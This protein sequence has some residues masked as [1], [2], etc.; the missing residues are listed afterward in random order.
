MECK[1]NEIAK[2]CNCK[3]WYVPRTEEDD[4]NL[5]I[6]GRRGNICFTEQLE[7]YEDEGKCSHC[8]DDCTMVHFFTA[9]KREPYSRNRNEKKKL[10]DSDKSTGLLANYLLDKKRIF[11]DGFSRNLTKFTFNMTSDAQLAEERFN[12]DLT[13]LNFFF[14]TP[15]ITLIRKE[16]RTTLYDL[17]SAIGGSIGLFGGISLLS[18]IETLYW[19][20]SAGSTYYRDPNSRKKKPRTVKVVITDGL[21]ASLLT[22]MKNCG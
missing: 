4:P 13:V 21:T 16:A 12:R 1:I 8:K 11:N 6:C 19:L 22:K 5:H 14:D 2:M 18:F 20:L 10:F 15:I 9:L 7:T 17:L 3:P